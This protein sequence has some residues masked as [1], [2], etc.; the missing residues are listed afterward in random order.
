MKTL[1]MRFIGDNSWVKLE[2]DEPQYSWFIEEY[3][4]ARNMKSFMVFSPRNYS[5]PVMVTMGNVSM[6]VF[7]PETRME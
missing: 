1:K 2:L 4:K 6:V 7:D 3:V 5:G